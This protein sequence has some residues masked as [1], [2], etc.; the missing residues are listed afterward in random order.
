MNDR[1]VIETRLG[2]EPNGIEFR[3]VRSPYQ[4]N[5]HG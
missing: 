5:S 2:Y 1:Y 4:H 3:D